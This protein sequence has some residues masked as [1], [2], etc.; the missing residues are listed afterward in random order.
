MKRNSQYQDKLVQE[1]AAHLEYLQSILLKF[2]A[3]WAP[4]ESTMVRY[5]HK[6]L[7]PSVWAK[8][9]QRGQEL[10]SFEELVQKAVDAEAKAAL[11]P[12][13]YIRN[14]N[15]YCLQSSHPAHSTTA[16]IPLQ[17]HQ[18]KDSQVKELKKPQEP[19]APASQRFDNAETSEKA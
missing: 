9:K 7:K 10:H 16:K 11:R 12:C 13:S 18:I 8:M 15:Q 17:G 2:D 19:N 4:A 1:W 5:F 14:T 6:G 3:E